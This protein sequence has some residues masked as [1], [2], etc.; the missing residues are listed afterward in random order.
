[1]PTRLIANLIQL[2]LCGITF[3]AAAFVCSLLIFVA[4]A[5]GDW[6]SL[7][8]A[9]PVAAFLVS[10]PLWLLVILSGKTTILRGAVVG[11]LTGFLS[12]PLAWY[13][14][15]VL[16]WLSGTVSSMGER[17]LNPIEAVFGSVIFSIF[18]L[19]FF[20]WLTVPVGAVVGG[21]LAA[22]FNRLFS[23]KV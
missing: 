16:M 22:I 9:A 8:F 6:V 21:V 20:G 19:L 3:G 2:A 13:I 11:A 12:H 5:Q 1:M 10:V 17:T 4:V 7:I 14:A 15:S 23:T 18:S